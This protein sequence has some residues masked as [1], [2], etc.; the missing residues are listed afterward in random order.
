[1]VGYQCGD[2]GRIVGRWVKLERVPNW[3]NLPEWD[4]DLEPRWEMSERKRMTEYREWRVQQDGVAAFGRQQEQRPDNF[5]DKY[6]EYLRSPEWAS[7]RALVFQRANG[8]CEGCGIREAT[9]AHHLTYARVGREM[10][11]DLV[12]ICDACHEVVH[13]REL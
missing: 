8:M 7:K 10:L 3:Q 12:A 13:G 1:M 5:W 2:C 9:Q 11:F 4:H 6:S